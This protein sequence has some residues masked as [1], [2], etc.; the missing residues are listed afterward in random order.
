MSLLVAASRRVSIFREMARTLT[1]MLALLLVA[2]PPVADAADVAAGAVAGPAATSA[3]TPPAAIAPTPPAAV[4]PTVPAVPPLAVVPPP[5]ASAVVSVPMPPP[6]P[7]GAQATMSI[8]WPMP[9]FGPGGLP[10]IIEPVAMVACRQCRETCF[11]DY[12]AQCRDENCRRALP[13][14]MRNCWHAICR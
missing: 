7:P 12:G 5:P 8:A 6:G 1:L 11:R 10:Q 13:L 2:V 3:S 14:C 4:A 9:G